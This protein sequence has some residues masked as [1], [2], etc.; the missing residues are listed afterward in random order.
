MSARSG[1]DGQPP[2]ANTHPVKPINNPRNVRRRRRMNESVLTFIY[3][4]G[5]ETEVTI[6]YFRALIA[7]LEAAQI[8][9]MFP[10]S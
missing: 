4:D 2:W 3:D 6:L 8:R 5:R 9:F 7:K 1:V 10:P